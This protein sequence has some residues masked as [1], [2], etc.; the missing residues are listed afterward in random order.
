MAVFYSKIMFSFRKK[1]PIYTDL[2]AKILIFTSF[3]LCL[4]RVFQATYCELCM[5]DEAYYAVMIRDQPSEFTLSKFYKYVN[6]MKGMG[7]IK[8][9]QLMVLALLIGNSLVSATIFCKIRKY[10]RLRFIDLLMIFALLFC[11]NFMLR[12]PYILLPSYVFMNYIIVCI[13]YSFLLASSLV[14]SKYLKIFFEFISGYVFIQLFYIMA[15]NLVLAIPV[16]LFLYL[17]RR[18]LSVITWCFGCIAGLLGYCLLFN[19]Y[20]LFVVFF[21]KSPGA[22]SL[23][24][25]LILIFKVFWYDVRYVI[26]P[27]FAW[28]I[29]LY[30]IYQLKE[31]N[32]IIMFGI[33]CL[34]ALLTFHPMAKFIYLWSDPMLLAVLPL[35]FLL[36]YAYKMDRCHWMALAIWW[37]IPL[38]LVLGSD[39][40]FRWRGG[41]YAG[42]Y[43]VTLY[44]FL[45]KHV[46]FRWGGVFLL[47]FYML[48]YIQS[49]SR[50]T[51]DVVAPFSE[52]AYSIS[53]LGYSD[54]LCVSKN[55]YEILK[56]YKELLPS[57][58]SYA[59]GSSKYVWFFSYF[60]NLLP[61][62]YHFQASSQ[63]ILQA[64]QNFSATDVKNIVLIDDLRQP[65][66]GGFY[67]ELKKITDCEIL[68]SPIDDRFSML[69]LIPRQK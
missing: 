37:L 33:V 15:T 58:A 49:W 30:S 66:N 63:Q 26:L 38:G 20:S 10:F 1:W 24:S 5:F 40:G 4:W 50:S 52:H 16:V 21:Q 55:Y 64:I 29:S 47:S 46:A 6:W 9:R 43:A 2:L 35:F 3:M 34:A 65:F 14:Y 57:S 39:T 18:S 27:M 59:A 32:R 56:N 53:N 11:G 23:S 8:Q 41:W 62:S 45:K 7:L 60:G 42:V 44:L 69:Q 61:L 31:K 17:N 13:S 25:R 36:L 22:G 68:R 12:F 19:D 28:G 67:S 54:S 48:F 51:G